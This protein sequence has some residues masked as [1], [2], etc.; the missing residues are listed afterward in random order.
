VDAAKAAELQKAASL[1][2][3][4]AISVASGQELENISPENFPL[5]FAPEGAS[6]TSAAIDSGTTAT[7]PS[8]ADT[9]HPASSISSTKSNTIAK[10]GSLQ[11]ALRSVLPSPSPRASINVVRSV[12]AS[13]DDDVFQP[14]KVVVKRCIKKDHLKP[15]VSEPNP[16]VVP[17]TSNSSPCVHKIDTLFDAA[18]ASTTPEAT[19]T[20]AAAAPAEPEK[21]E[22]LSRIYICSRTHSQLS[23]LI[24]GLKSTV[25]TPSMAVLGSREQ[26]CIHPSVSV[27]ET[28]NEDCS[29][30]IGGSD[31]SGCSFFQAANVLSNHPSMRVVWDIEDIVTK[32]RQF[33]ACPYFTAK[34]LAERADVVFCPYNYLIDKLIRESTG[35]DLKNNI[36]IFDEAHNLEDQ[37]REAASFTMT[38]T[39]ILAVIEMLDNC[40]HF[41]NCPAEV[42]QLLA[43]LFAIRN[44]IHAQVL[45]SDSSGEKFLEFQAEHVPIQFNE[46][47]LTHDVVKALAIIAAKLQ[48]W[49]KE[50]IE[51]SEA[52]DAFRWVCPTDGKTHSVVPA[53]TL[54]MR[55]VQMILL[56]SD[57]AHEFKIDYAICLQ[58]K[59]MDAEVKVHIW[60]LN[61]GVAFKDLRDQCRSVVLTSGVFSIL[62]LKLCICN[63]FVNLCSCLQQARCLPWTPSLPSSVAIFPFVLKLHMSS[64]ARVKSSV[65]TCR[66][67]TCRSKDPT[68]PPCTTAWGS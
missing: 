53:F 56:V 9:V 57:Y 49:H 34:D 11:K 33:R 46:M 38:D 58:Q 10:P 67:S 23:Q 37:C 24:K 31:G 16:P 51:L 61:P 43:A 17:S 32:G 7:L 19:S 62:N 22:S 42:S 40:K 52:P 55:S 13:Q 18:T 36:V 2:T 47:G 39:L 29:K 26:M 41:P 50:V 54:C 25:Y 35:I 66:S 15:A 45:C 63:C 6:V 59:P 60:C 4:S 12:G 48:D 27:S 20:S 65:I 64:I 14:E 28:K 21:K 44:W 8:C 1:T 30:L 5:A 3:S 68:H